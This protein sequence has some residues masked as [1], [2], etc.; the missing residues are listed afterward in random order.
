MNVTVIHDDPVDL[1]YYGQQ[2]AFAYENPTKK[3]SK[4]TL[5]A[6]RASTLDAIA[7]A[8]APIDSDTVLRYLRQQRGGRSLRDNAV[9]DVPGK[10]QEFFYAGGLLPG[11]RFPI[12]EGGLSAVVYTQV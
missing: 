12:P 9:V 4:V 10:S 5:P 1:G 7:E 8:G 11:G 2:S 6:D 3:I